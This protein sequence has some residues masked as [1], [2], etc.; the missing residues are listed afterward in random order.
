ML[1]D[2]FQ[3]PPTVTSKRAEEGKT[4]C[5]VVLMTFK[6]GLAE[7]M[8]LRFV[9]SGIEPLLLDTQYRMHPII[10]AFPSEQFYSGKI[11][12]GISSSDRNVPTGNDNVMFRMNTN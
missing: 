9:K 5:E 1:G 2:H 12:N 4:L 8:F 11:K 10:S 6:G 3:L 7:S